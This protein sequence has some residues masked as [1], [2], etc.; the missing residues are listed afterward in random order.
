M[1]VSADVSVR[2]RAEDELRQERDFI[3]AVLDTAATL[4]IVTDRE[5]RFVRFNQAC[6]RLTGYTFEEVEGVPY[7]ELFIAPR[8]GPR[9]RGSAVGRVWAGDFPSENENDWV[10]AG[11][12]A[13]G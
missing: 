8:G 4:V 5:G 12:V 2:K 7:W 3:S 9:V 10:T 13:D 1:A 11:R 6:E